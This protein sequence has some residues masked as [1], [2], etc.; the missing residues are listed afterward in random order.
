METETEMAILV[1]DLKDILAED[2]VVKTVAVFQTA[3]AE[4]IQ[5]VQAEMETGFLAG[6][7][8]DTQQTGEEVSQVREADIRPVETMDIHQMEMKVI[9]QEME[10][11][12]H[13]K[14]TD[15]LFS[16]KILMLLEK[17]NV[18]VNGF[19]VL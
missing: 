18:C 13:I 14:C 5:G 16:S 3:E 19:V 17:L 11:Q 12:G 8:E 7:M 9:R 15:L 4:D 1:V 6:V 10:F 2:R